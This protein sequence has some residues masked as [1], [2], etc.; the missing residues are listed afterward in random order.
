MLPFRV[1]HDLFPFEHRFHGLDGAAIP[2]RMR[3]PAS[4]C[5]SDTATQPGSFLYGRFI[6][7]LQRRVPCIAPGISGLQRQSSAAPGYR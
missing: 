1:P 2:C 6:A 4:R 3:G 7:G 5:C